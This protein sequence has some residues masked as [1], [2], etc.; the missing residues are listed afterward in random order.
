MKFTTTWVTHN[1]DKGLYMNPDGYVFYADGFD[2]QYN[3]MNKRGEL[4]YL[5]YSTEWVRDEIAS[6]IKA[7]EDFARELK[8]RTANS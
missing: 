4:V 7:D 5:N 1:L 6:A 8:S 2:N 3:V